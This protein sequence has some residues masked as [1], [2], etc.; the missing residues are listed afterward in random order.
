MGVFVSVGS[1]ERGKSSDDPDIHE[2]SQII[3]RIA[4]S[5]LGIGQDANDV[6]S[7][8]AHHRCNFIFESESV[9]LGMHCSD[10]GTTSIP[11]FIRTST[12]EVRDQNN[13]ISG[14]EYPKKQVSRLS[15]RK[16]DATHQ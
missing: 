1:L 3:D 14:W 10:G 12:N 15:R 7:L 11:G 6:C 13:V 4:I 5:V 9:L 16:G 8:A 2:G